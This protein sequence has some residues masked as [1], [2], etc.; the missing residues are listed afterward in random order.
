M[1]KFYSDLD[2]VQSFDDMS[3]FVTT[4]PRFPMAILNY[5][6][7]WPNHEA[8][9]QWLLTLEYVTPRL[10]KSWSK[11]SDV[12]LNFLESSPSPSSSDSESS[13]VSES[14]TQEPPS[15]AAP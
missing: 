3:T 8:V 7:D 5:T 9:C 6:H 14:S 13:W 10:L 15:P 12:H 2:K 11:W 4:H 1:D